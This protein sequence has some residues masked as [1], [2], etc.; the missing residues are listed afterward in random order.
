M[1]RP[2]LSTCSLLLLLL[3]GPVSNK[4]VTQDMAKGRTL[5]NVDDDLT[6]DNSIPRDVKKKPK[7]RDGETNRSK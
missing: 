7:I 6:L 5:V 2:L 3:L 1:I 4:T